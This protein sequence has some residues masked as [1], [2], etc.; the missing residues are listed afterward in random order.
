[1]NLPKTQDEL[2][3]HDAE[4]A[5]LVLNGLKKAMMTNWEGD[6]FILPETV[7]VFI[8]AYQNQSLDKE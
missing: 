2:A 3:R 6:T 1:M 4:V 5:V 8:E 7:D